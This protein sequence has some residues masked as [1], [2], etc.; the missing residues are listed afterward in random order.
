MPMAIVHYGVEL[1]HIDFHL[2]KH[3]QSCRRPPFVIALVQ[4]QVLLSHLIFIRRR[5]AQDNGAR[6]I[7]VA[8]KSNTNKFQSNR[9]VTAYSWTY[10]LRVNNIFELSLL[11]AQAFCNK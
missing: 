10:T 1:N 5:Q 9:R 4:L 11:A 2:S 3:N 8:A 6:Y 7:F